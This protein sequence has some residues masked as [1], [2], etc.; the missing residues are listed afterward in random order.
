MD[1][2]TDVNQSYSPLNKK[3]TILFASGMY[4]G[5]T[6]IAAQRHSSVGELVREACRIQYGLSSNAER[7]AMLDE[8]AALNLPVGS[9]EDMELESLPTVV[10][11]L[12]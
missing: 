4:T 10:E 8:L 1:T 6:R 11:L 2:D 5:L 7:L 12:P 9:V 3:T